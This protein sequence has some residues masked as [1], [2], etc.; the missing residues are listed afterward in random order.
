MV[1]GRALTTAHQRPSVTTPTGTPEARSSIFHPVN[2]AR[3]PAVAQGIPQRVDGIDDEDQ[4]PGRVPV[5]QCAGRDD[6]D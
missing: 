1:S 2:R 6:G 3:G 5:H 4:R